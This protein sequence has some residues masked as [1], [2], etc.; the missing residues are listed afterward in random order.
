MKIA[1]LTSSRADYGIYQPLFKRLKADG[2]IQLSI[3][4]FGSHCSEKF[5]NTVNQIEQDGFEF[6]HKISNLLDGDT[7]KDIAKSYAN[8]VLLFSDFWSNHAYFDWVI[9]LGDRF[10]M[11]AAVNAGIPFGVNFAHIHAGEKTLGAIDN[12]Y[13]HQIS[14]ASKLHFVATESYALRIHALIG[15]KGTTELVGSLSLE[16]IQ[17]IPFLNKSE[18]YDKWKIDLELPTLLMTIHPETV[19]YAKNSEFIQELKL[20]IPELLSD[21][22]LVVTLPN[23]DT[24]GSLFRVFFDEVKQLYPE[25]VRLIENFGIQS[26]FTCMKYAD[27]LIGNTS[28]GIIEAASF[29]KYVINLGNRQAGRACSKNVVTVPFKHLEIIA[30]FNK[31]KGK[32]YIG[33]NCYY[34]KDPASK[35]LERLKKELI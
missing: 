9:C 33:E 1:V 20:A 25:K 21:H 34:Q 30:E 24:F 12:V 26:Y 5:G 18:F 6:S 31:L 19:D 8:T 28:S 7:P 32:K 2:S 15:K 16:N 29:E 14:L 4:A 35:I 22:Q 17:T 10:E 13:R 27:L 11:A 23:A 3:V